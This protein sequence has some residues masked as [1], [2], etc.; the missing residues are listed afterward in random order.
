MT[1]T[2]DYFH[3]TEPTRIRSDKHADRRE[4]EPSQ[5]PRQVYFFIPPMVTSQEQRGPGT[6]R[7]PVFTPPWPDF[8]IF[9]GNAALTAYLA[10]RADRL[11]LTSSAHIWPMIHDPEQWNQK[12]L[13]A[14]A[15]E[16]EASGC[17]FKA[18]AS[19]K[20]WTLSLDKTATK[21][22]RNRSCL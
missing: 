15:E 6:S 11:G 9:L 18:I 4:C 19:R 14:I 5:H 7:D 3:T 12:I 8:Y 22:H 13:S 10:L 17:C 20:L 16:F 1:S 2:W 21:Q